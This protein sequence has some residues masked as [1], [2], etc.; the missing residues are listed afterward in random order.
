[1]VTEYF[2]TPCLLSWVAFKSLAATLVGIWVPLDS[3]SQAQAA[4]LGPQAM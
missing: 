4:S 2:I 3:P 1:M